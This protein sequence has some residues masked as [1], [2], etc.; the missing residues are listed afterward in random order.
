MAHRLVK[1]G[2]RLAAV[3]LVLTTIYGLNYQYNSMQYRQQQFRTA[4]SLDEGEFGGR[5]EKAPVRPG[6]AS[7]QST[8]FVRSSRPS[9]KDLLPAQKP[10]PLQWSLDEKFRR[11][12]VIVVGKLK[13]EDTS[14]LL[15]DLP[16]WQHV[17]YTVD[18]PD[19]KPKVAKN[20]G[21]EAN[22]YLQYIIDNYHKLPET[23]VFLHSH[24]RAWHNEFV[25]QSN[26]ESVRMMNVDV[27]RRNGYVNLRCNWY[28][29]CPDEVRPFREPRDEGRQPEHAF[30][31]AWNYFFNGT[32]VPEVIAAPCC[33][34]FAVS[35]K[36]IRERELDDYVR[37]HQWVM[38]T[39]WPDET[40]G[41][42][43][44]YMWHIIFG[45]DPVYCPDMG[46]CYGNVYGLWN[47][48]DNMWDPI[49][50]LDW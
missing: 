36:Q 42:V 12:G 37:Y 30:P 16:E 18:D 29:G 21:H 23:V 15:R 35:R 9:I 8:G 26:V 17:V 43:M 25:D 22:V 32:D 48:V 7:A 49:F 50:E 45:Q 4:F 47:P 3:I 39:E 2:V 27:V 6:A 34:Q 38:E 44:E 20:K 5:P 40:S 41:R 33:A 24:L 13:S 11:D 46:E 10:A 31:E 14:W 1:A 28:P 19:A